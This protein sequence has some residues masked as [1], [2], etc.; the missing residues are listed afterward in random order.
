MILLEFPNVT[1]NP[2]S[3]HDPNPN[4]GQTLERP[5]F[6]AGRT[7]TNTRFPSYVM[8]FSVATR[9]N[10]LRV[11]RS[12]VAFPGRERRELVMV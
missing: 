4:P 2:D 9:A 11:P 1:P 7:I 12:T 3:I 10:R 6:N 8:L 5:N